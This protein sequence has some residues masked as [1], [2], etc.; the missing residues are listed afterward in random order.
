MILAASSGRLFKGVIYDL[1]NITFWTDFIG[2][3]DRCMRQETV[4]REPSVGS[5]WR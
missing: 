1:E 5:F 3:F 4:S 2:N